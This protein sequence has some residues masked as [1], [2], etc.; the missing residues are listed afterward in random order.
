MKALFAS[1]ATLT[2]VSFATDVCRFQRYEKTRLIDLNVTY[3]T[4]VSSAA[5]CKQICQQRIAANVGCRAVNVYSG[6]MLGIQCDVIQNIPA[7]FVTHLSH[8][9]NGAVFVVQ[10]IWLFHSIFLHL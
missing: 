2:C 8:D 10:G 1:L 4:K 9:M 5:K 7:D 6:T 3:S